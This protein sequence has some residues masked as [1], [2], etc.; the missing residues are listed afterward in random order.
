MTLAET[1]YRMT[2][3]NPWPTVPAGKVGNPPEAPADETESPADTAR[4]VT[5]SALQAAFPAPFTG[6]QVA[7]AFGIPGHRAAGRLA[8]LAQLGMVENATEADETGQQVP[9]R[10]A[11]TGRPWLYQ[12][13]HVPA[14]RLCSEHQCA[15]IEHKPRQ[16]GQ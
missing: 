3:L 10:A 2:G 9:R 5:Y 15:H 1:F 6:P 11:T 13:P 7:A 4:R 16:S 8:Y 12:L 14:K